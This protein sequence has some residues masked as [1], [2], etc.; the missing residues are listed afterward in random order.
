M[1]THVCTCD[2]CL[3]SRQERE[4]CHQP[5]HPV[6]A[7]TTASAAAAAVAAIVAA[8]ATAA[9]SHFMLST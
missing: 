4:K 1:Y 7:V 6:A 2:N 9:D 3:G 8:A 5:P